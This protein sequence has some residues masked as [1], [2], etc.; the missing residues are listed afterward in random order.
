MERESSRTTQ[1]FAYGAN[2]AVI[3]SEPVSLIRLFGF[4]DA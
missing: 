2:I 4:T 3:L 1:L